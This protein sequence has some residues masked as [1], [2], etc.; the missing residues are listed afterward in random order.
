MPE[1]I[2][3]LPEAICRAFV[4]AVEANGDSSRQRDERPLVFG[5]KRAYDLYAP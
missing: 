4:Q 5:V 1:H 2:A 3:T